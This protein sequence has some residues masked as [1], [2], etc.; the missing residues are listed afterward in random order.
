MTLT[1]PNPDLDADTLDKL[2]KATLKKLGQVSN[3]LEK[4]LAKQNHGLLSNPDA[5]Y[6]KIIKLREFKQ[7]L[8]DTLKKVFAGDYGLCIE[9]DTP[10]SVAEL[11]EMAW[12][13]TCRG[14]V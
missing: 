3:D 9:C 12:A 1:S 13:D 11:T 5:D 2:R 14:C 10:L 4:L 7:H 8:N 6:M